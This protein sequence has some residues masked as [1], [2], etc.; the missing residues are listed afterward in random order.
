MIADPAVLARVSGEDLPLGAEVS[1]QLAAAAWESG[2][3]EFVLQPPR[4]PGRVAGRP[5][6]WQDSP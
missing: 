2:R 3:V 6:V 4:P 5:G 1:L